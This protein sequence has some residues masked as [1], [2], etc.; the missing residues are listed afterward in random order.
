MTIETFNPVDETWAEQALN[1][2]VA[3]SKARR[4]DSND[5]DD[6]D[7]DVPVIVIDGDDDELF[8]PEA[9]LRTA[10]RLSS[11]EHEEEEESSVEETLTPQELEFQREYFGWMKLNF[12]GHQ[13]KERREEYYKAASEFIRSRGWGGCCHPSSSGFVH[14]TDFVGGL[15]WVD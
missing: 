4:F 9:L 5:D 6:D 13:G 7:D 10:C 3:L 2:I 14:S 15:E 8:D 12:P 1:N 11:F